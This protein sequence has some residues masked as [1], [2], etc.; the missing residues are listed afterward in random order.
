MVHARLLRE[1]H[2]LLHSESYPIP[3]WQER[4]TALTQ[5][6]ADDMLLRD[7]LQLKSAGPSAAYSVLASNRALQ[8][9]ATGTGFLC[10]RPL[11]VTG[12]GPGGRMSCQKNSMTSLNSQGWAVYA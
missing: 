2:F 7:L 3:T 12:S 11:V 9:G 1:S 6:M 8:E 10:R 4:S 5:R